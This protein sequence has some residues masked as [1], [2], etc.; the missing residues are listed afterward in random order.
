MAERSI[1]V[2]RSGSESDK[3]LVEDHQVLDQFGVQWEPS[4]RAH[5][6]SSQGLLAMR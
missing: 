1:C 6:N 3:G 2:G 5:M 4:E